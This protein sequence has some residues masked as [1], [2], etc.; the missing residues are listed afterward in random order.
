M[1]AEL[2]LQLRGLVSNSKEL[3]KRCRM[4]FKIHYNQAEAYQWL[5]STLGLSAAVLGSLT[6]A[7]A[8]PAVQMPPTAKAVVALVAGASAAALSYLEPSSMGTRHHAAGVQYGE[9]ERRA[10]MWEI[11]MEAAP[12]VALPETQQRARA[13][14]EALWA[15]KAELDQSCPIASELFKAYTKRQLKGKALD[16]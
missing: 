14:L 7:A 12:D 10:R 3:R 11:Q 2:P 16:E 9:L 1:S 6:A 13:D 5:N 15:K 4:T 8:S